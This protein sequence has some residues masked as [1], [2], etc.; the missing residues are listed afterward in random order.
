MLN[1]MM[2]N[3]GIKRIGGE[4]SVLRC[5]GYDA[6]LM[7]LASYVGR[8]WIRLNSHYFPAPGFHLSQKV[9][10]ATANFEQFALGLKFQIGNFS[11]Y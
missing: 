10:I 9:S 8:Y 3:D 4:R 6:K 1:N 7:F 2:H 11:T 5:G